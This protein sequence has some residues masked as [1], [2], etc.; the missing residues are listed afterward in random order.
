MP[1]A[2]KSPKVVAKKGQKD[3]SQI[4]SDTKTQVSILACVNASGDCIP[5]FSV[6][7]NRRMRDELA[8]GEVPDTYY[9]YSKKGWM[10]LELFHDW[11]SNHF[12]CYS[13]SERPLLLLMD[14]CSSHFCPDMI[15]IAASEQVI[16]LFVLPPH[17]TQVLQP[18]DKGVFAAL[19][20][21]WRKVCHFFLLE[22]LVE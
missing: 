8:V 22:I 4:I 18:L 5:P 1:L 7:F 17:T 16:I 6:I 20:T 21:N 12:L 13:P 9:G 19:K 2:L 11:F 14:G 3:P 15:K 10:D